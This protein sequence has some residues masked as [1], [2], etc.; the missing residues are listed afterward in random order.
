MVCRHIDYIFAKVWALCLQLDTLK[1]NCFL[2]RKLSTWKQVS[3]VNYMES[4]PKCNCSKLFAEQL[5]RSQL[6]FIGVSNLAVFLNRFSQQK[7]HSHHSSCSFHNTESPMQHNQNL[8][9]HLSKCMFYTISVTSPLWSMKSNLSPPLKVFLK[10]LLIWDTA[11][12]IVKK[13][14]KR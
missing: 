11:L 10:T 12:C 4:F 14:L 3:S 8:L 13:N 1:V 2:P 5:S 6:H 7:S 9:P